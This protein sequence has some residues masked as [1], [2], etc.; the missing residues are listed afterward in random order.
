M[1]SSGASSSR[2]YPITVTVASSGC[3]AAT[4][5]PPTRS[6]T[7]PVRPS[8][9]GATVAKAMSSSGSSP[10]VHPGATYTPVIFQVPYGALPSR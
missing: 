2:G 4:G 6:S 3:P 7:A 1:H 8:S 5:N 10:P 9:A